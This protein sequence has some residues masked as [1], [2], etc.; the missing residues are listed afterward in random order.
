MNL[1]N[2]VVR[3]T[4]MSIG[5]TYDVNVHADVEVASVVLGLEKGPGAPLESLRM[6]VQMAPGAPNPFT[7]GQ[8]LA[9]TIDAAAV[10]AVHK[11][12]PAP[13]VTAVADEEP[14]ALTDQVVW[15]G[16]QLDRDVLAPVP[17]EVTF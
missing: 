16:E 6:Y 8:R 3:V 15:L 1:Q 5:T 9:I 10:P 7:L 12:P 4:E 11:Q 13:P 17:E 2:I 14:P